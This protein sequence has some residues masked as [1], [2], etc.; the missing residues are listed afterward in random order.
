[1]HWLTL[2]FSDREV[3]R[4]YIDARQGSSLT[5]LTRL[6]AVTVVL[7]ICFAIDLFWLELS[8]FSVRSVALSA[9]GLAF[10]A[11]TSCAFSPL[12]LI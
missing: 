2:K 7:N 6:C 10:G 12:A 11:F 1:M 9:G 5:K 8:H 3:E 4:D